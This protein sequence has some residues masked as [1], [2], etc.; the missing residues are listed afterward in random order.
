MLSFDVESPILTEV[1]FDAK[2]SYHRGQSQVGGV[3]TSP[4]RIFRVLA[5]QT[6]QLQSQS[7]LLCDPPPRS[8][9]SEQRLSAE[10]PEAG[11]ALTLDSVL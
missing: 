4:G 10:M 9:R 3:A 1:A 11:W 2:H 8:L 6:E 5:D 7:R